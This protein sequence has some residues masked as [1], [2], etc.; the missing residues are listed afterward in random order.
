MT[1]GVVD[2]G[3]LDVSKVILNPP[4]G[5]RLTEELDR[6]SMVA[7]TVPVGTPLFFDDT[8]PARE[9]EA[10]PAVIDWDAVRFVNADPFELTV[11]LVLESAAC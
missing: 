1:A 10:V 11:R 3:R 4:L 9:M 8:V 7:V 5:S 2:A 6:P